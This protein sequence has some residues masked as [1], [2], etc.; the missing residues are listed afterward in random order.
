MY[1]T[2]VQKSLSAVMQLN[3]PSDILVKYFNLWRVQIGFN[4]IDGKLRLVH[5]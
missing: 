5:V 3:W 1:S 4:L 2:A